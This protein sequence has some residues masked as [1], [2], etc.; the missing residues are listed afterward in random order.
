MGIEW[1]VVLGV[2]AA[3]LVVSIITLV[4]VAGLRRAL[5]SSANQDVNINPVGANAVE[6]GNVFC[7]N[8]GAM[9][10]SVHTACP[11][12]HTPRGV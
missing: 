6:S 5:R 11:S 12:C 1:V 7:R 10:D 8:C 3:G 9:Y 2:A 4:N